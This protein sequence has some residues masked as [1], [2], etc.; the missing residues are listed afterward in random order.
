ME[1]PMRKLH[2]FALAVALGAVAPTA[3]AAGPELKFAYPTPPFGALYQDGFLKW[4]QDVNA[5]AEGSAEIKMY[6][7]GVIGNFGNVYDRVLNGVAD[8]G[9]GIFG[10]LSSQFPKTNIVTLPFESR[11]GI[12]A[13]LAMWHLYTRGLI[14]DEYSKIHLLELH[15][16]PNVMLHTK[17]RPIHTMADLKGLKIS[18]EGR[19]VSQTVARL[20]ASPVSLNVGEL[21]PSL[22]RNT[23]DGISIAWIALETF[24][25]YEVTHYHVQASLANDDGFLFMNKDSYAKLPAKM[26]AAI[27]KYSGETLVRRIADVIAGATKHSYDLTMKSGQQ[28]DI[29][30]DPKEEARWR[31][32]VAPVTE[33]WVKSVPNGAAILAAYREEIKK[34]RG[35]M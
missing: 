4:T 2:A 22:Q 19:Y 18:A 27:D 34:A 16:Y 32:A 10:P 1:E 23:I 7:G 14:A 24:K 20:G 5:A 28:S 17:D 26:K 12:E 25:L 3:E 8:I 6:P 9:Q 33:D 11:N 30:L 15:V 13:G 29:T 35:A 31:A 21:Y